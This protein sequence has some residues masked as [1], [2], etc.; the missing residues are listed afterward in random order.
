[1]D[2]LLKIVAT[3]VPSLVVLVLLVSWFL[4]YLEKDRES[5][6]SDSKEA[7]EAHQA[8]LKDVAQE[9]HSFQLGLQS[10]AEMTAN[11]TNSV[12]EANTKAMTENTNTLTRLE[13]AITHKPAV[14]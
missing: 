1:M 4:G 13:R 8:S 10:K 2:E 14:T 3:Q 6:K 9:C 7:R 5:R 12:M 11:R